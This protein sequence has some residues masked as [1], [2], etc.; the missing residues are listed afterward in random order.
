MEGE[1]QYTNGDQGGFMTS[2]RTIQIMLDRPMFGETERLIASTHDISIHSFRYSSGVEALGIA[3][4]RSNITWLPYLGSEIW[5]WTIDGT[6]QKFTGFMDEP[7]YGRTFRQ[8]YGAFLIHCG[9]LAMGNPT[10]HDTHPQ[11]GEIP[12]SQPRSSWIEIDVNND[13]YPIALASQFRMHEPFKASYLF[14][15]VVRIHASGTK[16]MVDG[17]L[18]NMAKTPLHYQYL[19]HINFAYPKQGTLDYSIGN[20]T[21]QEVE[22]L[23]DVIPGVVSQ[24]EKMRT[25]DES[26]E[27]D[28]ELV[29]II[30]HSRKAKS[31]FG[32]G[33]HVVNKCIIEDHK[34]LWTVADTIA[35]DH[36]VAWLTKTPD[37][38]ACGFSLPATSGPTGFYH[39]KQ[40]GNIKTL[41][42]KDKVHLWFGFGV[43]SPYRDEEPKE[44]I[45]SRT[46]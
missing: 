13:E 38:G 14:T 45:G 42:G 5:D 23:Q 41:A 31:T 27:Y 20:F 40:K 39:E 19:A 21:Q 12:I 8:N 1:P 32:D 46:S 22:I 35:L 28:P 17:T 10:E 18:E 43:S 2:G 4:G 11:H 7:A 36:T 30:N 29:A 34:T 37:R 44:M 3:I 16:M 26:M 33:R 6:S 15:P 24:P 25:L 9:L